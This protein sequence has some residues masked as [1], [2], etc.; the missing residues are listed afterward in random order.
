MERNFKQIF[1]YFISR[2][3]I[4][5]NPVD[6]KQLPIPEDYVVGSVTAEKVSED[7]INLIK[8]PS[9]FYLS[10]QRGIL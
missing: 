1:N 3:Y 7:V 9:L 8:I 5:V 4:S 6:V 10:F 2:S